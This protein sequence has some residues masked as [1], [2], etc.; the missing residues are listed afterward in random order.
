MFG[1]YLDGEWF[2][3]CA[4]FALAYAQIVSTIQTEEADELE[5]D[6]KDE[7]EPDFREIGRSGP[8]AVTR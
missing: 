7:F 4:V 1:D 6:E 8:V 5:F 2:L 3:W